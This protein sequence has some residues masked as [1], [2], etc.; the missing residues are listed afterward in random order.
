MAERTIEAEREIAKSR[1]LISI[2]SRDRKRQVR[3]GERIKMSFWII[4][5]WVFVALLTGIN[6]FVFLKLKGASEQML[7]MAFPGAKDMN[8]A[9]QRMQQMTGQMGGM[10]RGPQKG[11]ARGGFSQPQGQSQDAQLKAAMAMLQ[12]MQQKGG[13]R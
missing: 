3:R 5:S 13:K 10:N 6:V 7:Q 8:D 1:C 4:T 12:N 2:A 11:G 9:L